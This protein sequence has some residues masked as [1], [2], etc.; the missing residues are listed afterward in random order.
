MLELEVAGSTI[1]GGGPRLLCLPSSTDATKLE[2]KSCSRSV[3]NLASRWNGYS[4]AKSSSEWTPALER[5]C[6]LFPQ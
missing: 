5:P 3:E 6:R 1:R 4:R 2:R